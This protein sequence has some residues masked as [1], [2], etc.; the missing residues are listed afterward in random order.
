MSSCFTAYKRWRFR[1]HKKSCRRLIQFIF[2]CACSLR[3]KILV[4]VFT[5]LTHWGTS[6]SSACINKWSTEEFTGCINKWST[7]EFTGCINKW[8]TKEFTGCI[9]KCKAE[10]HQVCRCS[11]TSPEQ[12][13]D[14][15]TAIKVYRNKT[16]A[17]QPKC[18]ATTLIKICG[19]NWLTKVSLAL[20]PKLTR[21]FSKIE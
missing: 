19:T 21:I 9:N 12:H 8:S 13:Q 11:K 5:A 20:V 3:N 1:S 4:H 18:T 17:P 14:S 7:K 6:K 2:D 16:A 10:R 15:R